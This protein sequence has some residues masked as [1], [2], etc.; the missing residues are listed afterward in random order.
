MAGFNCAPG[1]VKRR[2]RRRQAV[3]NAPGNS[4]G[5]MSASDRMEKPP[6][7]SPNPGFSAKTARGREMMRKRRG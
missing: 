7:G 2:R 3:V 6:E 5:A 4:P 1:S